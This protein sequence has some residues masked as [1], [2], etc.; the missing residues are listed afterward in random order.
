MIVNC[1]FERNRAYLVGTGES[2]PPAPPLLPCETATPVQSVPAGNGA[3]IYCFNSSPRID[4][5]VFRCNFADHIG[6]GIAVQSGGAPNIANFLGLPAFLW[7]TLPRSAARAPS[8]GRRQRKG[9]PSF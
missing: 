4:N 6:G 2:P 3:G 7:V 5:C 8:A 9:R 1:I